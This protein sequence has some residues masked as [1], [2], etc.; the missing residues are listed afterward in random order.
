MAVQR[1]A[2][3]ADSVG[4]KVVIV[5]DYATDK[6]DYEFAMQ[7]RRDIDDATVAVTPDV[8]DTDKATGVVLFTITPAQSTGLGEGRY[9]WDVQQTNVVDPEDVDHDPVRGTMQLHK[10]VTR[11]P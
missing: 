5:V 11:I 3:L 8:D 2:A 10:S 1:G 6:S 7:W 9:Y 4:D